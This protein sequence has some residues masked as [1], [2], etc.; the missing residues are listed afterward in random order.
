MIRSKCEIDVRR[1]SQEDRNRLFGV[2]VFSDVA[3]A[4]HGPYV[5]V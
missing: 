3:R 5:L 1:H 4:F 2:L